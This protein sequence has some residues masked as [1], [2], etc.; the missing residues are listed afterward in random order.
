MPLAGIAVERTF[1]DNSIDAPASGSPTAEAVPTPSGP[2]SLALNAPSV[3]AWTVES[4][5]RGTLPIGR[6]AP[7]LRG[8]EDANDD[9]RCEGSPPRGHARRPVGDVGCRHTTGSRCTIIGTN[10]PDEL[11][12]TNGP[13]VI[14]ARGGN[15]VVEGR[16][17][18]DVI[19]GGPGDDDFLAG[20]AGEDVIYG[21]RG[22]DMIFGYASDDRI[23]GGAGR[24]A[25][26][27]MGGGDRMFG[28]GG[29]DVLSD[30]TGQ[31]VFRGG[32]GPDLLHAEDGE[33][34]DRLF[35]GLAR[36]SYCA[37]PGDLL[38][39]VEEPLGERCHCC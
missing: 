23:Y 22:A 9:P 39:S 26:S 12:G 5:R 13:D 38:R 10:G 15:D 35:G 7:H 6:S 32:R 17:G 24:D 34:A 29:H 2:S 20:D 25:L 1:N 30:D 33:G 37:D 11:A 36:D 8:E 28:Q 31:D 18:D 27:G 21:D 19:F 4:H 14:C 16:G 3:E